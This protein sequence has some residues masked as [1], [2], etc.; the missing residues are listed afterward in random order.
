MRLSVRGSSRFSASEGVSQAPG[1]LIDSLF[2]RPQG[3]SG[4]QA[5][6]SPL[7]ADM[8]AQHAQASNEDNP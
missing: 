2:R 5:K 6:L 3:L 7:A 1:S 4:V 8:R